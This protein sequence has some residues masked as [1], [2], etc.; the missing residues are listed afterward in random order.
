MGGGGGSVVG[1]G[2]EGGRKA[3][4]EGEVAMGRA[5]GPLESQGR[6]GWWAQG[7]R[8]TGICGDLELPRA[9][10]QARKSCVCRRRRAVLGGSGEHLLRQRGLR[11]CWVGRVMAGAAAIERGRASRSS[12]TVEVRLRA[13]GEARL[14]PDRELYNCP[15][16]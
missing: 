13:S 1:A 9:V 5:A 16:S 8:V 3:A 4:L 2:S 11:W 15:P 12:F 7:I 6:R 10:V 14:D